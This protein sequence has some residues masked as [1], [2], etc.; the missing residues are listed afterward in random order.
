MEKYGIFANAA[1][2]N[3]IEIPGYKLDTYLSGE[4]AK[5]YVNDEEA[6]LCLRGTAGLSDISDDYAI[7]NGYL[8]ST[9]RYKREEDRLLKMMHK[10]RGRQ[11][12]VVGHSLGASLARELGKK[13]KKI[14]VYAYNTGASHWTLADSLIDKLK[15]RFVDK[16]CHRNIHSFKVLGDP[17]SLLSLGDVTIL[18]NGINV[19]GIAN[20]TEK[21]A[22]DAIADD[23]LV[24][25]VD[26]FHKVLDNDGAA[27]TTTGD[28]KLEYS[29]GDKIITLNKS[30]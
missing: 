21:L 30:A 24:E 17:L 5:V 28:E 1:Y 14:Q 25:D 6:I 7:L 11:F 29:Q 18:P 23:I 20:F 12:V 10:Y 27:I 4:K 3:D 22:K 19:H 15:C 16:Y 2:E 26:K 13:Y 9:R 8:S